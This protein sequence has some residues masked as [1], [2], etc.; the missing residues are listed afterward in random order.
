[1]PRGFEF[2]VVGPHTGWGLW[3][4]GNPA[5]KIPPF[6]GLET[7]LIQ[8]GEKRKRQNT[9]ADWKS[10]FSIMEAGQPPGTQLLT[11]DIS[12]AGLAGAY[13]AG[14]AAIKARASYIFQGDF[15]AKRNVLS[16]KVGTWAKN[17]KRNAIERLGTGEDKGGLPAPT[18]RNAKRPRSG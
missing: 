3:V 18:H 14:V 9:L 1:M 10:I 4:R 12:D 17:T 11:T 2:P 7:G 6:R 8:P 16:W 5:Q 15:Y 13:A